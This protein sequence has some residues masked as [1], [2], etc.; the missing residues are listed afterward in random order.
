MYEGDNPFA[1]IAFSPIVN[2]QIFAT[3]VFFSSF[4]EISVMPHQIQGQNG[5]QGQQGMWMYQCTYCKKNFPSSQAIA[6]H[7]KGHFRDGWVKGTPQSKVFVKFS[8][9]QQQQVSTTEASIPK[10][11]VL[12]AAA[13][14]TDSIDAH[15]LRK[16]DAPNFGSPAAQPLSP[17]SSSRGPQAPR[18]HLR[19]RDLK[20]LARLRARLTKE[21]QEVILR[22]LDSAM[23]QAK[24][25]RK[26]STEVE[27][28]PNKDSEA[29][30]PI[31]T[32]SKDIDDVTIEDSDDESKI[33]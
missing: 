27:V 4:N 1:L 31:G 24:Q 22:L 30:P 6:G 13:S 15:R 14:N 25:S 23:E 12:S 8:D 16:G 9:Y 19:L 33:M 29:A 7:T 32:T 5:P 10:K 26:K 18:H 3:V 2:P 11:Q 28:T 21:E 17:A 20:I